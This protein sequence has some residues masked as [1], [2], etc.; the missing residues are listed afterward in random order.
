MYK[1]INAGKCNDKCNQ[2]R[3]QS[4]ANIHMYH[5]NSAG[6]RSGCVTGWERG[7][8]RTFD[9]KRHIAVDIAGAVPAENRFED[10]VADQR[11]KPEGTKH[12]KTVPACIRI[13]QQKSGDNKPDQTAVADN[14]EGEH[15]HTET[16]GLIALN[17][18]QQRFIKTPDLLLQRNHI[19][20]L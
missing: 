8:D 3:D 16:F 6:K 4:Q 5:G 15:Q 20:S 10:Q 9:E 14:A 19:L 13:K 1:Q 17:M 7:A 11:A 18:E 12:I 2:Q